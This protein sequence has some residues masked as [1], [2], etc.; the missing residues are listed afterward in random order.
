MLHAHRLRGSKGMAPI[1][2]FGLL[3]KRTLRCT[4]HLGVPTARQRQQ[5]CSVN[6]G[7]KSQG[8]IISCRLQHEPFRY[9]AKRGVAPQRKQKLAR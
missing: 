5:S 8:V 2:I 9:L 4:I 3:P 7:Q 6:P 1:L